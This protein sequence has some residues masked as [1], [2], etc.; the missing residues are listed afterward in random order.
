MKRERTN[1]LNAVLI[2]EYQNNRSRERLY[3][4]ITKYE[5]VLYINN[6]MR[7]PMRRI[8]RYI[9]AVHAAVRACDDLIGAAT[10][11]KL[12][13]SLL[14]T[15]NVKNS[16]TRRYLK[17]NEVFREELLKDRSSKFNTFKKSLQFRTGTNIKNTET[18]RNKIK[19]LKTITVALKPS[20]F[21]RINLQ[22][23]LPNRIDLFD[24]YNCNRNEASGQTFFIVEATGSNCRITKRT[25][26]DI[27]RNDTSPIK[28]R[29][30]I[31]NKIEYIAKED[32]ID[33]PVIYKSEESLSQFEDFTLWEE[34]YK[35]RNEK[36]H[37]KYN[38]IDIDGKNITLKANTY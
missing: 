28:L 6:D 5:T 38:E 23:H 10:S 24:L 2:K 17:E 18:F 37:L 36:F 26:K 22:Q 12:A 1:K 9:Y 4:G 35:G 29:Y 32:F 14:T 21:V 31:S 16:Y 7:H 19:I 34:F 25:N 13:D 8:W 3:A 27:K 20:D 30:A 33:N 15:Y 11:E